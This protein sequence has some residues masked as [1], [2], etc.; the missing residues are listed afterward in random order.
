MDKSG[1]TQGIPG[2]QAQNQSV[3]PDTPVQYLDFGV[4]PAKVASSQPG[5]EPQH[6]ALEDMPPL[7]EREVSL[8]EAQMT[9]LIQKVEKGVVEEL[10]EEHPAASMAP[11]PE[12]V[13]EPA[14]GFFAR[15]I[16]KAARKLA[17]LFTG[18][19]VDKQELAEAEK[20]EK[21]A[22]KVYDHEK[23]LVDKCNERI[24]ELEDQIQRRQKERS[25]KIFFKD[26]YAKKTSE[27]QQELEEKRAAL[28][29]LEARALAAETGLTEASSGLSQIASNGRGI[30]DFLGK[31]L[32]SVRDFYAVCHPKKGAPL[33][34]HMK[35]HQDSVVVNTNDAAITLTN[36]DLS[37]AN[38]EFVKGPKDRQCPIFKIDSFEADVDMPLPDGNRVKTRIV[39]E[40]VKLGMDVGIGGMLMR[41]VTASNSLFA[42]GGLLLELLKLKSL[43]PT[44]VSLS[45][46]A[47]DITL[48]DFDSESVASLVKKTRVKPEPGINKL[49]RMINNRVTAKVGRVSIKTEGDLEGNASLEGIKVDYRPKIS[50]KEAVTAVKPGATPRRL[51]VSCDEAEG[52]IS[53]TAGVIRDVTSAL[54]TFDPMK[55]LLGAPLKPSA[56]R[57]DEDSEP[58]Q[59]TFADVMKLTE[60]TYGKARNVELALTRDIDKAGKDE[61]RVTGYDRIK[62]NAGVLEVGNV[63][64]VNGDLELRG[65]SGQIN[66]TDGKPLE[67]SAG[68]MVTPPK[69]DMTLELDSVEAG[70]NAETAPRS[71]PEPVSTEGD[72]EESSDKPVIQKALGDEFSLHGRARI[73]TTGKMLVTGR[74]IGQEQEYHFVVPGLKAET[75]ESVLIKKKDMGVYI[76]AG[77]NLEAGGELTYKVNDRVKTF[78]PSFKVSGRGNLYTIIKGKRVPLDLNAAVTVEK[79]RPRRFVCENPETGEQTPVSVLSTGA[80]SFGDIKAGPVAISQAKIV[81][82]NLRT[83]SI[84]VSDAEVDFD[85]LF[86]AVK[87]DDLDK[88]PASNK[89]TNAASME[90]ETQSISSED[91]DNVSLASSDS[92][93]GEPVNLREKI[94]KRLKLPLIVKGLLRHKKVVFDTELPIEDGGLQ[95]DR[96]RA[97]APRFINKP[98][99]NVADRL[100]TRALN[101]F[102][103]AIIRRLQQFTII[104]QEIPVPQK[105]PHAEPVFERKPVLKLKFPFKKKIPLPIPVDCMRPDRVIVPKLIHQQSG[106]L[107]VD[108]AWVEEVETALADI[109]NWTTEDLPPTQG[110]RTELGLPEPSVR[111]RAVQGISTLSKAVI[112]NNGDPLQTSLIHLIAKQMPIRAMEKMF[113]DDPAIKEALSDDLES[114]ASILLGYPNLCHEALHL[115]KLIDR[116]LKKE[117][118]EELIDI[119][120][121]EAAP[122]VLP[123][124]KKRPKKKRLKARTIPWPPELP[125]RPTLEESADPAALGMLMEMEGVYNDPDQAKRC[126]ILALKQ[127]KSEALAHERLGLLLLPEPR[128]KLSRQEV[129]KGIRH[130]MEASRA[131]NKNIEKL[132]EEM[133]TSPNPHLAREAKL[134][135]ATLK[136]GKE[137][138]YKDFENAMQR[139]VDLAKPPSMPME[140][141]QEQQSAIVQQF[142]EETPTR[143]LAVDMM[144]ERHLNGS[145]IFHNSDLEVHALSNEQLQKARKLL[146]KNDRQALAKIAG[147][148][149][150]KCLYGSHG[151]VRNTRMAHELLQLATQHG[152]KEAAIHFDVATKAINNIPPERRQLAPPGT[153]G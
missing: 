10:E 102:S 151:I 137:T 66:R 43:K 85:I 142:K 67:V 141:S 73:S 9:N 121:K 70:L 31:F 59:I 152:D 98:G 8:T 124:R 57:H 64:Q 40:G 33:D 35:L 53:G 119:Q 71:Q 2:Q 14:S 133:E 6:P 150:I 86:S 61:A 38:I 72:A 29:G 95:I 90:A 112:T 63:G 147:E 42:V 24:E 127:Q 93:D 11:K 109:A 118:V 12:V 65:F 23:K 110:P 62:V 104:I 32:T 48:K 84:E 3:K 7:D 68:Q 144:L 117:K 36:V 143:K 145:L 13:F 37:L 138:T 148:V 17:S 76:P 123:D 115:F 50:S 15:Q 132:L 79:A 39:L 21:A 52:G 56:P 94:G 16:S 99:A 91:D 77:G 89:K 44:I 46:R 69:L 78:A 92:D 49:F 111:N 116:P 140:A 18:T 83:G 107:M 100:V 54:R 101:F 80:F 120:E 106:L 88:K 34:A 126:Y 75:S 108:E 51:T 82:N 134:S 130:L 25:G 20:K 87:S 131:G 74:T 26:S 128:E 28:T 30:T 81:L 125:P 146:K 96:L 105:N 55:A 139:L 114:C 97:I 45:A 135:M 60:R 129:T 19:F 58:A 113:E 103:G 136:L 4:A 5:V 122:K 27:L 41:Y 153:S 47:V 1:P 22:E 149:G